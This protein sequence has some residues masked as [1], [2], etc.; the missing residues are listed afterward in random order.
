MLAEFVLTTAKL[1]II[2]AFL[3][4]IIAILAGAM[5][6]SSRTRALADLKARLVDKGMSADDIKKI[7]EAGEDLD[8]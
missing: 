2:G 3:V 8:D 1:A 4:P 5:T 6:K 7:V